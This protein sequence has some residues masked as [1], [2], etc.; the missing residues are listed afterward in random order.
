MTRRAPLSIFCVL[1]CFMLGA[2]DA[3][4]AT[5]VWIDSDPACDRKRSHDVDDCWALV[6]ALQAQDLS[7]R[8][9]STVFGNSSEGAGYDVVTGLLAQITAEESRPPVFRGARHATVAGTSVGNE[10]ADALAAALQKESL[11]IIALGPLTNIATLI[12]RYPELIGKIDRL[13]AVAGQRPQQGVRFHPGPSRLFHV[14]DFNFRKDVDA[15]QIVLDAGLP[16]TLLPYEAASKVQINEQDLEA[17]KSANAQ[18]ELLAGL[19]AP[20]LDYW[21]ST[22]GNDSFYPFDSLAVGYVIDE[23][24][25]T[26]AQLPARIERKP[27][28]FLA[29]RDRLLVSE[30]FAGQGKVNYCSDVD[31]LFKSDLLVSLGR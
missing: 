28:L 4:A 30:D 16:V 6:R 27:S 22:F 12:N 10:A 9:I 5:P 3:N 26:C 20:W 2:F 13:V 11:T 17:M 24:H 21:R 25:F 1:I 23:G 14:H 15:F 7:V 31:S 18:S 8:G 29:S 19:A